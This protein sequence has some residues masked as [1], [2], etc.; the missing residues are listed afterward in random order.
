MKRNDWILLG[1][2]IILIVVIYLVSFGNIDITKSEEAKTKTIE[3]RRIFALRRRKK[4]LALVKEK[5]SLQKKLNKR[6][7]ILYFGLRLLLVGTVIGYNL[8]LYFGFKITQIGLILQWNQIAFLIIAVV[9]FLTFG[10]FTNV[11]NIVN[12]FKIFIDNWVYSRFIKL[13]VQIE[14]HIEEVK[15]IEQEYL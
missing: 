6:F 11:K 13:P 10:T 14:Q 8:I 12:Y 9:L 7:R 15:R 2:F 1:L 3:E 4:L 5:E